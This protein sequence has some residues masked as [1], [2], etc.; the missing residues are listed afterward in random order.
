MLKKMVFLDMSVCL[1]K[2]AMDEG[3]V[4]IACGP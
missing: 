4:Y 3:E 1:Q 2:I